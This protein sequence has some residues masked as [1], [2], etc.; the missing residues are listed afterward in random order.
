MDWLKKKFSQVIFLRKALKKVIIA[1]L[2][3]VLIRKNR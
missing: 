2:N 1:L 3:R